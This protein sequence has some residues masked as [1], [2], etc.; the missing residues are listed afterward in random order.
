MKIGAHSTLH[1]FSSRGNSKS[2]QAVSPSG[3]SSV[4]GSAHSQCSCPGE[5]QRWRMEPETPLALSAASPP[6]GSAP[7]CQAPGAPSSHSL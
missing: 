1:K 6:N 7:H 5:G 4:S 2:S 3:P